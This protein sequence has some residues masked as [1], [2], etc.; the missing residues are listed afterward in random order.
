MLDLETMGTG[1]RAAIVA[2]GAVPFDLQQSYPDRAFYQPV[3]LG[4]SVAAGMVMEPETVLWWLTQD[5][6]AR[7]ELASGQQLRTVLEEFALWYTKSALQEVWSKGADFDLV[8]MTSAYNACQM[9]RP[10]HYRNQRCF[11]T[12]TALYPGITAP[13]NLLQHHAL[14]DA[15]A[16]ADH[17]VRIMHYLH[18]STTT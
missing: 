9:L 14:H 8:V 12:L 10:W 16:Q 6:Q 1:P 7:R 11:R 3:N 17:A 15:R 4:S 13:E 2:V 18:T 5:H